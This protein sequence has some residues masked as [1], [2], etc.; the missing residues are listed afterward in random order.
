[1]NVFRSDV[2]S[3]NLF[4][5]LNKGQISTKRLRGKSQI[6]SVNLI[7]KFFFLVKNEAFSPPGG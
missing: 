1:M 5:K 4:T 3:F 2:L 7:T 6:V